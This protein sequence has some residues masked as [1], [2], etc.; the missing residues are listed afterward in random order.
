MAGISRAQDDAAMATDQLQPASVSEQV[1]KLPAPVRQV[2]SVMPRVSRPRY[3]EATAR[4]ANFDA[5][6][7]P[8]GWKVELALF[9]KHDDLAPPNRAHA[10]FE[11]Q[12]RQP[13][14]DNLGFIDAD[15]KPIRWTKQLEFDED[16]IASVKLPLTS[17]IQS[18][19]ATQRRSIFNRRQS[20]VLPDPS[21]RAA[22]HD[23]VA[24]AGLR[25]LARSGHQMGIDRLRGQLSR[26]AWG[27]LKVRV[28]VPTEGV[29]TTTIGVQVRPS[30][31]VD[32][33]W[34]YR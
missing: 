19:I 25:S 24:R 16:G 13:L 11:L 23:A 3:V 9:D 28:S 6:A 18:I 20:T 31:L 34:P 17:R 12:P 2:R 22:A 15:T 21:T 1:N 29:F 26:P 5:D 4:L 14:H 33:E 10:T 8:D 27:E 30:V 7:D 32:T